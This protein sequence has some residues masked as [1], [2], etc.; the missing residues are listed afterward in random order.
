LHLK[1]EVNWYRLFHELIEGFDA[2]TLGARQ[3]AALELA[4]VPKAE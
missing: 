4:G 3:A 2:E 1:A